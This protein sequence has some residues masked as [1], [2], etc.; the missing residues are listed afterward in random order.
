[1]IRQVIILIL[2]YIALFSKAGTPIASVLLTEPQVSN[3][4]TLFITTSTTNAAYTVPLTYESIQCRKL[5]A[6]GYACFDADVA[7]RPIYCQ[8]ICH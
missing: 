7:T 8:K 2:V 3:K 6:G 1:M 5:P 4:L